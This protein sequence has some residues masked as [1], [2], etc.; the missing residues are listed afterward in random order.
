MGRDT[1]LFV[2]PVSAHLLCPLC[3]DV[4]QDP[5][6]TP[7]QHLFCEKELLDF[8]AKT[9][10]TCCPVDNLPIDA[11]EIRRPGRV[12]LSLLGELE[13]YCDYKSEGCTWTGQQNS[14]ESHLK[15]CCFNRELLREKEE[16]IA[17][18][19]EL[20]QE[21]EKIIDAAHDKLAVCKQENR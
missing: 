12:I 18:L 7:C 2:G 13:R 14:L 16:R 10:R 6:E 8:Y 20:L 3:L 9:G 19:E 11:K 5:V 4:L 1:S 15:G 21:K 17:A